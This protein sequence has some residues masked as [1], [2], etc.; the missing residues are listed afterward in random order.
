MGRGTFNPPPCGC[1]SS[2]LNPGLPPKNVPYAESL[3]SQKVEITLVNPHGLG[4]PLTY[5]WWIKANGGVP[6]KLE[7]RSGTISAVVESSFPLPLPYGVRVTQEV[8]I[9]YSILNDK[10]RIVFENRPSD[11]NYFFDVYARAIAPDGRFVEA[12]STAALQGHV[13]DT[14]VEYQNYLGMCNYC[15]MTAIRSLI[16][17]ETKW[18]NLASLL[19][20]IGGGPGPII[21]EQGNTIFPGMLSTSLFGQLGEPFEPP[22]DLVHGFGTGMGGLRDPLRDPTDLLE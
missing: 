2:T 8:E 4:L 9:H 6:V 16:E 22:G 19:A 13:A 3:V 7:Q 14:S 15:E 5:E 17:G 10:E 20:Q 21:D 1:D 11:G 12:S 18:V